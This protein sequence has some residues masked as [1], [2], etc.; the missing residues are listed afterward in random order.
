MKV[1][2]NW[3]KEYV[4]LTLPAEELAERL[5]MAGLEVSNIQV[6]GA[7]WD[8]IFVGQIVDIR[9]HPNADRLRLA[10]VDLAGEREV[11]VCGAPNIE[12][13]QK[14][15]FARVGARLTDAHTGE[16]IA[17][18]PAKIRGVESRG[19]VC[20]G[21]ELGISEDHEGIM[22]LPGDAPV[23]AALKD[24]L[25]DTVLDF[26]LTPNRPDC[27]SMLGIAREVS[28]LTGARVVPP[29]AG[30]PESEINAGE[31][32]SVE[33]ADPDLCRRYC[34]VIVNG[35]KIG[36]SP[37][38]MQERLTSYGMRP[39]NNIVDI[40]NY[41]MVE[42][43]QPLHA[44]DYQRVRGRK[45]VVRRAAE[46]QVFTSLDGVE[47]KLTSGDLMINDGE[48]PVA[49]AGV[50]GGA[51]SEVVESTTSILLES[52]N[53][54]RISIRRTSS[55]L[56]LRSEASTRFEK[57][58]RPELAME[59]IKRASR[60]MCELGR[61]KAARGIIDAYPGRAEPA[62]VSVSPAEVKRVLGIDLNVEEITST[63]ASL[64]FVSELSCAPDIK[65]TPP[66]WRS[67][68]CQAADVLEEIARIRGYDKI[69]MTLLSTPL[70]A[71]QPQP[72]LEIK[73][74]VR[75]ILAAS[76]VQEV[77]TYTLTNPEAEQKAAGGA[78]VP[79]SLRVVNPLSREQEYLRTSLRPG[80]L[81]TLSSNQRHE[82]GDIRIFEVGRVFVPR[83]RE[84]PEDREMV[85]ALFCGPRMA[86]SWQGKPELIDFYDAKG[87]L[88]NLLQ[89][90]GIEA[91]FVD[92]EDP[93]LLKGRTAEVRA[94]N[95]SLGVIGELSPRISEAFDISGAVFLFELRLGALLPAGQA[96]AGK[97][98]P[99][100]RFPAATRDLAVILDA[101][102]PAELVRKIILTSPL[103]QK[104]AVFDVYS[105]D[106]VP[107][108]KKSLAWSIT[109]QSHER[110]L[111]DDEV[112]VFLKKI[113][114]KLTKELGATLRG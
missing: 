7:G 109:W 50:M 63:L 68:I 28:A 53:F 57:G 18:Q 102:V 96:A 91:R 59:A 11:V 85:A 65:V 46:G 103:V 39:I 67:D 3:L 20:S 15:P 83:E 12:V 113:L 62:P 90:L 47:R 19:M 106:R 94:G 38:W 22:V 56:G 81:A 33:I 1:S 8:N 54:D 61:G 69:P 44:F 60:L 88:E 5:T 9:P 98:H 49:I 66:W 111:T 51:N 104:A 27:F 40:T 101:G 42:Y 93:S 74:R 95:D 13:G 29:M 105:G 73:D 84:L 14:V 99:L 10:E 108:G 36:P 35:V 34:A 87:T 112:N 43:G 24:Y 16:S 26:E 48:G 77:I 52:A 71:H 70:P 4:P 79:P 114:D 78:A 37:P 100:A 86:V 82:Q 107:A 89:R 32:A 110:T 21:R 92:S 58:L 45:I 64:G 80:L 97:Y 31:L 72:A 2:L 75:D 23:G 76:G 17:L 25:G 6:K 41:V 30:Y 55:R